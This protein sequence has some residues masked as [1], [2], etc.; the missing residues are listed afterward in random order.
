M[1]IPVENH[2]ANCQ[3]AIIPQSACTILGHHGI[4]L[5]VMGLSAASVPGKLPKSLLSRTGILA[6]TSLLYS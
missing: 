1:M 2:F 3:I 4:L 5:L 6:Q